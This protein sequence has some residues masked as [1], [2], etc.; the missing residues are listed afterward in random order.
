MKEGP[1]AI[2]IVGAESALRDGT[3][4]QLADRVARVAILAALSH[5]NRVTSVGLVETLL[6]AL[7]II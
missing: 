1:D 7:L 6:F 2:E 5:Q 4:V 3:I